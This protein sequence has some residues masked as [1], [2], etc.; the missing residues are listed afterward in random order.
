M[1]AGGTHVKKGVFGSGKRVKE[2]LNGWNCIRVKQL[3]RTPSALVIRTT[4]PNILL[5]KFILHT[6]LF[7]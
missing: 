2:E 3:E 5:S 1:Y 4:L 6:Y 7:M